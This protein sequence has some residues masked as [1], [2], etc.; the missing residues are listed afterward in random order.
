MPTLPLS[1]DELLTTTRSVRKRLDL[2][3]PVPLELVHECLEVA[4][5]A[6]SASNRQAWHWVVINELGR[7]PGDD[8]SLEDV[9]RFTGAG[10]EQRMFARTFPSGRIDARR[11]GNTFE[12]RTRGVTR[13]T[14]LLSPEVIDF[15]APVV[16]R[17]NGGVAFDALVSES[18][19][20]LLEW[21]ARDHDR[22]MLYTAELSVR[23]P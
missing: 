7:R 17:V 15:T 20:T 2:T 3:R 6:P 12:V 5:Q 4:L 13:F 22:T 16:V 19:R 10:G 9:N 14:L 1:P 18:V 23:V 21:H 8:P 11:M